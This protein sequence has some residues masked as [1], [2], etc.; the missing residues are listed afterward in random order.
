MR[1][2]T[3][4][5]VVDRKLAAI[6]QAAA[7][8]FATIGYHRTQIV[9]VAAASGVA[10]G[11]I[12]RHVDSK[13]QL[14]GL[15]LIHGVGEDIEPWMR[16]RKWTRDIAGFLESSIAQWLEYRGAVPWQDP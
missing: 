12:Y 5:S 16:Q 9:D 14:F 4:H 2:S 7:H 13:A 15:A 1:T 11:T 10:L 6:I 3:A 8:T